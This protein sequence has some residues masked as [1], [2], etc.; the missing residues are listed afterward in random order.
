MSHVC[1][2]LGEYQSGQLTVLLRGAVHAIDH[3]PLSETERNDL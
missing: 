2:Q 1:R 3:M